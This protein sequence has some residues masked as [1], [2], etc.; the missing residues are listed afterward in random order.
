MRWKIICK[1]R[2]KEHG[3]KAT[4]VCADVEALPF[5]YHNFTKILATDLLEN[6][7][8]VGNAAGDG[9]RIALLNTDKRKE[10]NEIARKVE[11]IELTLEPDF[12]KQFAQAM[13]FPH[14]KDTFPYLEYLSA[15]KLTQ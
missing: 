2:Q 6:V 4:L 5:P 14:M 7:Y 11:Y 15:E 12:G 13:H 9:A 10:A 3:V 8:S 1:Q